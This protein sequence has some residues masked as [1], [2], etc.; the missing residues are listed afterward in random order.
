[1]KIIIITLFFV[2][3]VG[4]VFAQKTEKN[5]IL[6]GGMFYGTSIGTFSNNYGNNSGVA[7]CLGGRLSFFVNKTIYIGGRGNSITFK[8]EDPS[9]YRIGSGGVTCGY[10]LM[11]PKFVFTAGFFGGGGRIINTHITG[12]QGNLYIAD[13]TSDS[14]F[15]AAPELTFSYRLSEKIGFL[16]MADYGIFSKGN[17][18]VKNRIDVCAG[19]VFFR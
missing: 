13:I 19:I 10:I 5:N 3:N 7:T 18:G 8:Y 1:M 14:Y 15:F 4:C 16:L 11:K 6:M 17:P 12:R 9:V 2:L